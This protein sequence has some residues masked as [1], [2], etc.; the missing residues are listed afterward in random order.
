MALEVH[1]LNKRYEIYESPH[2]RLWQ[3]LSRGRRCFFK[4]F[5]ALQDISF[6]LK[7]GASMGIIGGNGS[8]KSTLLQIIAGTLAPTSGSVYAA[9]KISA[10]LELGS[11]F[12]PE[13]TGR[14]NVFMSGAI[15]GFSRQ[16]IEERF[17][18]IASFA[19]IGEFIDYPV[20]IYSSGMYVRLAFAC[21]VAV[22][23]EILIIDEALAVG[24]LSFQLKCF[25]KLEEFRERGKTMIF[26]SHSSDDVVRLCES[27]IWL[28]E[29]R[30]RC[31]GEAKRVVEK[32]HGATLH[33]AND[34]DAASPAPP[35]ERTGGSWALQPLPGESCPSGRGGARFD[36]V[37][38]FNRS[39]GLIRSLE[40]PEEIILLFD[41]SILS[42]IKKPWFSFQ[43]VN[44]RGIRV[45]GSATHLLGL[46]IPGLVPGQRVRVKFDFLFPELENGRYF[47]AA[48]ISDGAPGELITHQNVID[49]YLVDISSDGVFQNLPT[50]IKLPGCSADIS[51][52][53]NGS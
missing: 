51:I 3:T 50:M 5:W 8:G 1:N 16:E 10:L 11:G 49:S 22:D 12:D 9:G 14:E 48:G 41:V 43:L 20:K 15:T 27:A 2:H 32:Y 44:K 29:G 17:D 30:I 39:G 35:A 46:E 37:G 6:N 25:I 47:I 24:D 4:E 13:F 38:L 31:S 19:D 40:G 53:E 42:E 18:S 7:K 45:F 28:D 23:P 21:A 36:A 34:G 52:L 26:V 33:G